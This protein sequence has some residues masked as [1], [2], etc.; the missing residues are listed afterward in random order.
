[1]NELAKAWNDEISTYFTKNRLRLLQ[2]IGP[3]D[4]N[5]CLHFKIEDVSSQSIRFTSPVHSGNFD[6]R[7]AQSSFFNKIGEPNQS[8]GKEYDDIIF[9]LFYFN[10]FYHQAQLFEKSQLDI[11]K[12]FALA[13]YKETFI[14]SILP[15]DYRLFHVGSERYFVVSEQEQYQLFQDIIEE[16]LD[17]SWFNFG[18]LSS[19]TGMSESHFKNHADERNDFGGMFPKEFIRNL[20]HKTCGMKVFCDELIKRDGYARWINTFD[21][22]TEHIQD[23]YYIY[24]IH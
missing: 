11:N 5:T 18:M 8:F 17:D 24:Q 10:A 15:L 4:L 20:I 2:L 21:H 7:K 13:K 1:M 12:L 9:K 16:D 19:L 22:T 3:K 14:T 23:N 6:W